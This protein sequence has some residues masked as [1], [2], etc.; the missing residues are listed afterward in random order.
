MATSLALVSCGDH[1]VPARSDLVAVDCGVDD[2]GL[3][4]SGYNPT[5]RSCLLTSYNAHQSA[6]LRTTV[7]TV[8]GRPIEY[9]F[10]TTTAGRIDVQRR[11]ES[12]VRSFQCRKLEQQPGRGGRIG[13]GLS[14]CDGVGFVTVP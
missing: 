13:L 10:T 5:A 7:Y 4:G 11:A 2:A 9:G 3:L 8:E 12:D 14:E 6:R 1:A